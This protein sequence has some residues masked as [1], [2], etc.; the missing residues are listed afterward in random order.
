LIAVSL[1]LLQSLVEHFWSRSVDAVTS[2]AVALLALL[3]LQLSPGRA[4]AILRD[5]EIRAVRAP[6]SNLGPILP[7]DLE[8][9]RK[10]DEIVPPDERV[11]LLGYTVTNAWEEW[12]FAYGPTR[13]LPFYGRSKFAF[14]HGTAGF[15]AHLYDEHVCNRFDLPWLVG[16]GV[17]WVFFSDEAF[18]RNGY[19]CPHDW[20]H[21]RDQY[22]EE[23]LR[24][25]DRVLYRLR[26]DYANKSME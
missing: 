20:I 18:W 21:V 15:P 23:V 12:N 2:G 3:A 19:R 1:A 9:V 22:F 4:A 10:L 14:F 5:Y 7:G 25:R 6:D 16:Q 13:A 26:A 17:R 11:L 24:S 8:F